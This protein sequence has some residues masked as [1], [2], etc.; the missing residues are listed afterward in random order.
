MGPA[1]PE[2]AMHHQ[3]WQVCLIRDAFR[4]G[5]SENMDAGSGAGLQGW[6]SPRRRRAVQQRWRARPGSA[7]VGR[8]P[9]PGV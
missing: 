8:A 4:P 2:Q 5:A 7:R 6:S 3:M 1:S 9:A